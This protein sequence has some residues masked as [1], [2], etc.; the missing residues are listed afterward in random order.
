M[1]D[2]QA[3][4]VPGKGAVHIRFV[5][6][7]DGF[8]PIP[9][10]VALAGLN[11]RFAVVQDSF[12]SDCGEMYFDEQLWLCLLG[13]IKKYGA[14]IKVIGLGFKRENEELPI[15]EFIKSW[16]ALNSEDKNPPWAML[17]SE[18]NTLKISLVTEYWAEVGGPQPYSDSYT[19]SIYSEQDVAEK[20][21]DYIKTSNTSERW[22]LD[23]PVITVPPNKVRMP[24]AKPDKLERFLSKLRGLWR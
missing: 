21:L 20:V 7:N 19:Y 13:F 17:V 6:G 11:Y 24:R 15:N 5:S 22:S 18:G 2:R 3:D 23:L 10:A 14:E 8:W 16:N 4:F 1:S 12:V 9:E